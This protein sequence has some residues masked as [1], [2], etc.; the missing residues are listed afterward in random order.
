[1]VRARRSRVLL[2]FNGEEKLATSV[3]YS[4]CIGG[5]FAMLAAQLQTQMQSNVGPSLGRRLPTQ[6]LSRVHRFGFHTLAVRAEEIEPPVFG[7]PMAP[8]SIWE[9]YKEDA[10]CALQLREQVPS[11]CINLRHRLGERRSAW[12]SNAATIQTNKRLADS[13]PQI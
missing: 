5:T 2:K 11:M 12:P 9:G 13:Q 10:R 3:A 1:M 7:K 8:T 4:N 6:A